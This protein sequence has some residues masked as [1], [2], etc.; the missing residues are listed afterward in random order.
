VVEI[1]LRSAQSLSLA[2][3]VALFNAAYEGYVMPFR[4]EEP[5][6]SFME[7]SFDTDLDAS[8]VAFRDGNPVGLANL[9]IR[10]DEGWIGGVGVVSAARRQGLGETLMRAVHD[11]ARRAG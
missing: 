8:R 2:D 6:L 7:S 5:S 3:R 10:G 4:L 1:E 9:A 11:E